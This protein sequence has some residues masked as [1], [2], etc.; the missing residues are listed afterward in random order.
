MNKES[1]LRE[2]MNEIWNKKNFDKIE[3]YVHPEYTIYLDTAD[4]WEGKTITHFEF[5]A[6]TF[7]IYCFDKRLLEKFLRNF[8]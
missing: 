4:L 8:L 6:T 3:Q 7:I 1:F 2:F 5:K